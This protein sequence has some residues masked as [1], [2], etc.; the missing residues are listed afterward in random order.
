MAG[1]SLNLQCKESEGLL[2]KL[3]LVMEVVL[4]ICWKPCEDFPKVSV[5]VFWEANIG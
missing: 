4:G 3:E 5:Q 2:V 1:S